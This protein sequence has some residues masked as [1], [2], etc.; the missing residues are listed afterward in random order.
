M[1]QLPLR[2]MHSSQ[3]RGQLLRLTTMPMQLHLLL[4]KAL[5]Y[6]AAL[7]WVWVELF[8]EPYHSGLAVSRNCKVAG[9]FLD[10]QTIIP[11]VLSWVPGHW[12][13]NTMWALEPEM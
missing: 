6:K 8:R 3:S 11:A 9:G 10:K 5:L 7:A 13:S 1:H 4:M 12:K 2:R